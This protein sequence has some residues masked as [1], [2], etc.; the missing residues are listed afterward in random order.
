MGQLVDIAKR[1]LS[2]A[3]YPEVG[4][5]PPAD[6]SLGGDV[7]DQAAAIWEHK[8]LSRINAE[9]F[10]VI[11]RMEAER[12]EWKEMFFEQSRQHLAAQAMLSRQLGESRQQLRA[13]VQQL[14]FYRKC[15]DHEPIKEPAGLDASPS[16]I[17]D[18]Y[19][20]KM[21]AL[22]AGAPDP[23]DGKA[24]RARIASAQKS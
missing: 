1:I 5:L 21:D 14:N 11:E 19:K 13:A 7:A 8:R 15:A 12:D 16:A 17:P 22:V 9:Y 3:F 4:D 23:T 20:A 24:A 18:G 10:V 6:A 2:E